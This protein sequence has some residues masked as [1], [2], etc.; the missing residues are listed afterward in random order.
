M[1]ALGAIP[2]KA[3]GDDQIWTDMIAVRQKQ[4]V[5]PNDT[6][7][8]I[9]VSFVSDGGGSGPR[10]PALMVSPDGVNFTFAAGHINTGGTAYGSGVV[11]A[12]HFYRVG[13]DRIDAWS[14]LR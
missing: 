12:G 2:Q 6:G 9:T 7:R 11:P 13:G 1:S 14:E 10:A 3:I 4:V 8:A 5:Y